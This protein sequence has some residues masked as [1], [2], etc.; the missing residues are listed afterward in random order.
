MKGNKY[1]D[2]FSLN[3]PLSISNWVQNIEIQKKRIKKEDKNSSHFN[4]WKFK[5]MVSK[6]IGKIFYCVNFSNVHDSW[7]IHL[8]QWYF[9]RSENISWIP[10]FND[11]ILIVLTPDQVEECQVGHSNSLQASWNLGF[12]PK[13]FISL[14]C[15]RKNVKQGIFSFCRSEKKFSI[16]YILYFDISCELN[17]IE[18]S[19]NKGGLL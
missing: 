6:M 18:E 2:Q 12:K 3:Q 4:W 16:F 7:M 13:H 1:I 10:C 9:C 17:A 8:Y 15:N 14:T 5:P 11:E 19:S